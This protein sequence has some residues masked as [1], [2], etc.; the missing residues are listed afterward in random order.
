[1][2]LKSH[3]Y[4]LFLQNKVLI[5]FSAGACRS[6]SLRHLCRM[7]Y[8]DVDRHDKGLQIDLNYLHQIRLK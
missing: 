1:M 4:H 7:I 3:V 2:M 6:F 8:E 5:N